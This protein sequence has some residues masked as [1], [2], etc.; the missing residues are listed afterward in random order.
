MW[1]ND[2]GATISSAPVTV[3]TKS[4]LETWFCVYMVEKPVFSGR[5]L[6]N[7]LH[8]SVFCVCALLA[9][10][11]FNPPW[12]LVH[13]GTEEMRTET[14]HVSSTASLLLWTRQI[15]F[16]A[17][18]LLVLLTTHTH[19]NTHSFYV[20]WFYVFKHLRECVFVWV[21]FMSYRSGSDRASSLLCTLSS[22]TSHSENNNWTNTTNVDQLTYK[23]K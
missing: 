18:P 14:L 15:Q 1:Y 10:V 2:S 20:C 3:C 4:R 23:W 22:L 5:N 17:C 6:H 16:Q 8:Y 11:T 13:D 9:L 12:L 19:T 7:L 21:C